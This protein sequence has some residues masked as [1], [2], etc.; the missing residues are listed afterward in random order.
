MNETPKSHDAGHAWL[1]WSASAAFFF[2]SF[3]HR[4]APG[5]MVSDLMADFAVTGAALGTLSA[6][7]FYAY[8]ALQLPVGLI[9]DRWGPRRVLTLAALV[10]GTGSFVFGLAPD[11]TIAAFGRLMIGA[12]VAFAWIGTLTLISS[13]FPHGRFAML[14][15][16]SSMIGVIGAIGAQAPL[17]ALVDWAGW[18]ATMTGSGL[19]GI[20]VSVIV[21]LIVRDAPAGKLVKNAP[22]PASFLAGLI[23]VLGRPQSLIL[24]LISFSAGVFLLAFGGLWGVPYL[25]AAYGLS[26]PVAA[27]GISL[28]MVGWALGAPL[29]G[30]VSDRFKRRKPPLVV[31]MSVAYLSILSVIYVPGLP[32]GAAFALLFLTGFAGGVAITCFAVAREHNPSHLG[33]AAMGVVNTLTM[34]AGAVYQPLIGWLLDLNWDG[35]ME[36]GA[37]I[38]SLETYRIALLSIVA[39][40]ILA[41]VACLLTKETYCQPQEKRMAEGAI[42]ARPVD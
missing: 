19:A 42:S 22:K 38:Y 1:V 36:A 41:L 31:G 7:Y 15:G 25:V 40:G 14:A 35:G 13:W 24:G 37:Q 11:F 28:I 9:L 6:L 2:F 30:W 8:T 21:W 39:S 12:G 27:S 33:G 18:R 23:Q 34:A 4:V 20:A 29:L 3:F 32:V 16:L 26:K 5:V 17:A 10:G